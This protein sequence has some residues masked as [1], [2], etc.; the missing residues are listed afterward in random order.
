MGWP[1]V[2]LALSGLMFG[3]FGFVGY[4]FGIPYSWPVELDPLILFETRG[5][6]ELARFPLIFV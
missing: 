6:N 4:M 2:L 3:L 5:V 1:V